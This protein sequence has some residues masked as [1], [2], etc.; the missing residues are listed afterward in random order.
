MHDEVLK[1]CWSQFIFTNLSSKFKFTISLTLTYFLSFFTS[2]IIFSP[3]Y[4]NIFVL[5]ILIYI[6]KWFIIKTISLHLIKENFSNSKF[7]LQ[8]FQESVCDEVLNLIYII[9]CI[10]L[11]KHEF[12]VLFYSF[13]YLLLQ[14]LLI[15]YKV[16][17]KSLFLN[18][19][20]V[21]SFMCIYSCIW[22]NH[23]F[24]ISIIQFVR[25]FIVL[26]NYFSDILLLKTLLHK[27]N[28]EY[29]CLLMKFESF[30]NCNSWIQLKM[31]G[32]NWCTCFVF[33]WF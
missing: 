12:V 23:L 8:F 11:L 28:T 6:L 14:F 5:L 10:S 32:R 29:V 19:Y 4:I 20:F 22:V 33:M 9:S 18:T 7:T 13:C 17:L 2:Y 31:F 25:F 15:E 30:T 3:Y 1:I 26:L 27:E 16:L 21:F 24:Y